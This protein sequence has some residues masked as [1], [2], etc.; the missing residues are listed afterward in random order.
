MDMKSAFLNSFRNEE[1]YVA[2]PKGFVE[3]VNPEHVY[4][5]RKAPYMVSNKLPELGIND[6]QNLFLDKVIVEVVLLKGCLLSTFLS[7]L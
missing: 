7:S 4:K 3:L 2:K 5:L 6:C 1:V